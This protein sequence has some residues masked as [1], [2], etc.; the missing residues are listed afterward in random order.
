MLIT[1]LKSKVHRATVTEA[2]LDYA[3][4]LTLDAELM[5]AANMMPF[6]KVQVLNLNNGARFETYL[7][8]GEPGSGIVCLNGPAAR[9]GLVGDIIIA[10]TYAQMTPEEAKEFEPKVVHVDASNR[11]RNID[12]NPD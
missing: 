8:V 5:E 4:S 11:I 10:L 12:H 2:E 7:I 3:G 1:M 9:Q 6:E